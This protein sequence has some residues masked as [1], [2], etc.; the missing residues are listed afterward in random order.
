VQEL[1]EVIVET[2]AKRRGGVRHRPE[3]V[4]VT[5]GAKHALFNLALALYGPGDEVIIPAPY[6]VSYPE[7]VRLVGA[8]AVIAETTEEQG[9]R[10]QP[11]TLR[12]AI[13]D[14]TRALILCTPSNPTGSAYD[15]DSLKAL[16]EVC[17][18]H[19][20][21]IIVDEIYGELIYGGFENRSAL[22]LAPELKD[23]M[24]VVDG[25]SKTYAMTGW[26]IGW[27]L[28]PTQVANA[29]DTLQSQS[30]SNPTAVAQYAALA[31]LTG[32]QEP[33]AEMCAA[34]ERRRDLIIGR[35]NAIDGLHARMPEGAFYAFVDARALVGRHA[36][37]ERIE[38]D[39]DLAGYLLD[40]A[41]CA[42]VPG[43]A[44]GAPGYL[45]MSY[46]TSE[47]QIETGMA[48]IAAA[49]AKLS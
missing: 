17:A 6:W 27:L 41:C 40:E 21:W 22:E 19:D 24:V 3:E 43:T 28:A 49:V 29:C 38:S 9:F 7:Q 42:L 14:R 35:I 44:F 5:V 36:A 33:V 34:F 37:G 39:V 25:V 46:A 15:A 10:L 4:V 2:S 12:A 1:R 31:A 45:R 48:R 18:E 23:R 11:E 30:T 20:F 16:L 26:R 8:T 13:T 32:P 47:D